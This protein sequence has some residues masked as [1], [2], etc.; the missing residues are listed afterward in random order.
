MT[1]DLTVVQLNTLTAVEYAARLNEETR[2]WLAEDA[3]RGAGLLVEDQDF[4]A[5]RG[6]LS[7]LHLARYLA[8]S[9]F[10]DMYKE[11]H[12]VR[13]RWV[14]FEDKSLAEIEAMIEA[15]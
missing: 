6:I 14:N 13:P 15:L 7:G 12:G 4:W 2:A 9:T 8:A 5:E 1:T 3:G 11:K 10:S